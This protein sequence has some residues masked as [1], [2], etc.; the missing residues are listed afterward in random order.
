MRHILIDQ[1]R[2]GQD[3]RSIDGTNAYALRCNFRGTKFGVITNATFVDCDLRDSD[4]SDAIWNGVAFTNCQYAGIILP[5]I[6]DMVAVSKVP[7]F[8]HLFMA[9]LFYK[10]SERP[11]PSALS[12]AF[13]QR[14]R[15]LVENRGMCFA[16][17]VRLWC[18]RWRDN[19]PS[20][21]SVKEAMS[22][23]PRL[24]AAWRQH[25]VPIVKQYYPD[26]DWDD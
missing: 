13:K 21:M 22:A 26:E 11:M 1:D 5:S 19:K 2:S 8:D 16:D 4:F 3:L 23:H 10:F 17:Y 25:A 9:M 7:V 18:E 24:K 6:Q 12:L 20:I 15:D 14:A